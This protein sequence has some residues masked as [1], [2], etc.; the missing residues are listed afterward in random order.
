MLDNNTALSILQNHWETWIT[1]DDF[2]AIRD[3]GLNHVRLVVKH[4]LESFAHVC[5]DS[6]FQHADWVLVCPTDIR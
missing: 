4:K 1:E 3:A 2:V 5:L 6:E